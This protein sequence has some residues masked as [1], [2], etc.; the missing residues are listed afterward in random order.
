MSK[1]SHRLYCVSCASYVTP[2]TS[3]DSGHG[4]LPLC[5]NCDLQ[6][7]PF[8][9]ADLNPFGILAARTLIRI[10]ARALIKTGIL[11]FLEARAAESDTPLDDFALSVARS[12]IEAAAAL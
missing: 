5:P 6:L 3:V 8:E 12:I 7:D 10:V 1:S 11:Q 4:S 2:V 9:L